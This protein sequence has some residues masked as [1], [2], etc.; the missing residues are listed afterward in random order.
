MLDLTQPPTRPLVAASILSADFARMAEQCRDVLEHGADLLHLDVMDG[1]FVPNLTMGADMC[2]A[3]RK[4]FPDTCLDVHLMVEHPSRFVDMFAD[5][6]ANLLSFHLEVSRPLRPDGEDPESLIERIHDRGLHAGLAINPPTP[7][8]DLVPLLERVEL[9]LVMS[10]H[11][12]R[13]GQSFIP[14]VLPKAQ[15]LHQLLGRGTRLEM[16]GGMNPQTAA[17][18]VGSGVDVLV[19]ASSLF[20]AP[21]PAIVIDAFH[22]LRAKQS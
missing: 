4:Y 22:D 8:D 16:D 17:Q 1:H 7:F 18:A 5:A 9:V 15:R 2:R 19:T 10:V 11:P 21:D 6:G 13:S 3:L 20:G 12:G 14:E